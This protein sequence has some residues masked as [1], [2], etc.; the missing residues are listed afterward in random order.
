VFVRL[1][2]PTASG[3][4]FPVAYQVEKVGP[5]DARGM[6]AL[7]LVQLSPRTKIDLD[8]EDLAAPTLVGRNR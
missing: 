8:Q 6:H 5:P 4:S 7:S 3:H 1:I 2:Y